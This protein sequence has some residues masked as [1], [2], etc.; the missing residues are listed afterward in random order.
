MRVYLGNSQEILKDWKEFLIHPPKRVGVD[1]ETVSI[2][3]ISLIGIGVAYSAV[4]AFYITVDD[5]DFPELIKVLKRKDVRKVY[6]NAPFDLRVLRKYG[7][8]VNEVDDTALMARLDMQRSAVLEDVSIWVQ[9]EQFGDRQTSRMKG[10]FAEHGVSKVLDLP[11]EVLARKCCRDA[12]ATW[13]LYEYFTDKIHM[14]YYEK[15]RRLIGVLSRISAQG[16]RLDQE[17]LEE[18]R[19]YYDQKVIWWRQIFAQW[20]VNPA[21]PKQVGMLLAERGNF[22]PPTK[23]KTA[24]VTDSDHLQ[25][26]KDPVAHAVLEFR[27]SNKM[28]GTYITP[29]I[30]CERAYTTLKME[31]ATGRINSTNAGKGQPDRNLQNIPKNAEGKSGS[32]DT[33]RS[34]FIPDS[35]VFT[36]MDK[37]Q[38]EL[39]ILAEL[40]G[41]EV[42]K[43]L[44][45]NGKDFHGDTQESLGISRVFA[46]NVNFSKVYGGG[47]EGTAKLIGTDDVRKV[48]RIMDQWDERYVQASKWLKQQEIDGIRDGYVETMGG[49][50]IALPFDRGEDHARKCARN[51][52][53]QGSAFEDIAELMLDEEVLKYLDITRLQIHDELILDG[54]VEVEGMEWNKE[55]SEKE[56]HNIWDVTGRL[57]WLS[58]YYAPLEV[59]KVTR[60]G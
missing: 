22:L 24:L 58:G 44:F 35:G 26:L 5:D 6:H 55:K 51:Y 60:W 23:N 12:Q 14:P 9:Y 30:G 41:D 11:F 34:A 15:M 29:L 2:D 53:I 38:V 54:D 31:A 10:L 57:A 17:R 33:I 36:K 1:T 18:L 52:P 45:L 19:V 4:D 46:K 3:D 8:D 59:K 32:N 13:L 7:V 56:G 37:S 49:R 47:A 21:S 50:K 25:A 43:E 16:I 20:G 28:L 27:R 39:R 42:M 48:K 40:S